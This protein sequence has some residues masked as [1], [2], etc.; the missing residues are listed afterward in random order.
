MQGRM[1]R[2]RGEVEER[3]GVGRGKDMKDM[4]GRE[5]EGGD[6]WVRS[7]RKKAEDDRDGMT[8]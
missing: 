2:R 3:G 1:E 5:D 7:G 4:G 6:T 8:G